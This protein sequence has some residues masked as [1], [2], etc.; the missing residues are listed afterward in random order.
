VIVVSVLPDRRR[1]M[2]LGA[3]DYLVKPVARQDLL[4][5]VGRVV[6]LPSTREPHQVAVMVDDDPAA[7][8]LARLALEPAGWTVHACQRA[9]EVFRLVRETQPDVVLVDLLMPEMDGFEVIDRLRADAQTADVPIVVITARTL[10]AADRALLEGRIEF[11]T[12]K[13]AVELKL[14]AGRLAEIAK[15]PAGRTAGRS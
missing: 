2:A 15:P 3:S 11:V 1:G 4:A 6:P 9:E 12:S 13:N 5:A 8:E 7:M 10:T 14:L